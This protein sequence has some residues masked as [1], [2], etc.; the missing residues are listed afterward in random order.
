[1][2]D[3]TWLSKVLDY[4][5]QG[6]LRTIAAAAQSINAGLT[7]F[8]WIRQRFG[9]L[10]S[11]AASYL[12]NLAKQYLGAGQVQ[13]NLPGPD[14]LPETSVPI[15]PT[16]PAR[17]GSGNNVEY[18]IR[19]R[20]YDPNL[21]R[22]RWSAVIINSPYLLTTDELRQDLESIKN[23]FINDSP[24]LKQW[25]GSDPADLLE[26]VIWGIARGS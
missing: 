7:L 6:A 26:I 15:D 21:Q 20:V 19:V 8:N 16:L 3:P 2:A 18:D 24:G 1:M 5:A 14:A 4:L 13:T 25:L 10:T 23:D 9:G 11:T 22:S 12:Y 17:I